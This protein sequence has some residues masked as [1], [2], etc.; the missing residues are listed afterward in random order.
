ML[1]T[2]CEGLRWHYE[3]CEHVDG[4]LVRMREVE[5]GA[6]DEFS[7]LFRTV[8]VAFAYA[9]MSAAF[10][11][12]PSN[13]DDEDAEVA[14]RERAFVE[15]SGG[16]DDAGVNGAVLRGFERTMLELGRALH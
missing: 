1:L 8:P 11:R 13:H 12:F 15:L 16:L 5:T 2:S 14:A 9:E 7:T 4:Y 3:V 6:L 10:D